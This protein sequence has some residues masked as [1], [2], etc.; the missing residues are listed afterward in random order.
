MMWRAGRRAHYWCVWLGI[1]CFSALAVGC[2]KDEYYPRATHERISIEPVPDA[3]IVG[4][5]LLNS[6][7]KGD[8]E[9]TLDYFDYTT[10]TYYRNVYAERNP[11]AVPELGDNGVD[12]QV[13]KGRLYVV[14]NGSHRVEVLDA[15]TTRRLGSVAVN[16]CRRVAFDSTSGYVTSYYKRSAQQDPRQLGGVV[17]FDLQS[18]A[19]TGGITVGYQPEG[20][21][22]LK[23]NTMLVTNSGVYNAPDYDDRLSVIDLENFTQRGYVRVGQMP[24]ELAEDTRGNVWVSTR[25]AGGR[26]QIYKI[27]QDDEGSFM[28]NSSPI[29]FKCLSMAPYNGTLY[30]IGGELS[31]GGRPTNFAFWKAPMRGL[32][33]DF[34][35]I[36]MKQGRN[37]IESPTSLVVN[38]ETREYLVTDAR[39]YTSSGMLYC[40]SAG[41]NLLWRV[42]TGIIPRKIAFV[43]RKRG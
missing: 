15:Y 14:L 17:R 35:P 10:S 23:K 21:L 18:L 6:G 28:L 20:M 9:A 11:E 22:V 12:V 8:N 31:P 3:D 13:W 24:W 27:R 42:R 26:G 39:N 32:V 36:A 5:Y 43:W 37:E 16:D 7:G 29:G 30:A 33:V 4:F 41:G 19:I 1:V 25:P 40:Y 34:S 38:P 2:R